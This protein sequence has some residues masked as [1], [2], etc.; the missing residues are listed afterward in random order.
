ME[1]AAADQQDSQGQAWRF[2]SWSDG[3][4]AA[5]PSRRQL[6]Q[7]PIPAIFVKPAAGTRYFC[8]L[9]LVTR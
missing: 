3:G 2:D 8:F 9:P 1:A 4:A 6:R 5:T 7:R